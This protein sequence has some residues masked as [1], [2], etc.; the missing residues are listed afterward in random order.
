[1]S[2][3]LDDLLDASRIGRG[4]LLLRKS[5][6]LLSVVIDTALEAARPHIEAKR[7]RLE[8]RLPPTP[9]VLDI[10]PVRIAQVLGNLLTNAAKYT[11]PEGCIMVSAQTEGADFVM[12]VK[13]N[14]IGLTQEQQAHVFDMF[15][16]VPAALEQSQGGLGIGL[17]LAR[18]LVE[19]HGGTI[20]ASSA[21]LGQGTEIIVRLPVSCVIGERVQGPELAAS[22]VAA[23]LDLKRSVLVADD[24]VDAA[25]SLAELLRLE[26]FEV[27]VAYD[28]VAALE[29][30]ARV[31]PDAALLDVSMPQVSGLDVVRVIRG[32]PGGER[33]MLIAVTGWG[34][35]RDRRLAMEAGFDHHLTKPM[36]LDVVCQLIQ[37]GRHAAIH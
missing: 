22:S 10:D 18:G 25:D 5:N 16:Q 21:G 13:D 9:L 15:S 32:Q 26:G 11:H 33:A 1:M 27:Y 8:K 17:A 6:E 29:T 31:D 37:Q 35:E 24:N 30:F 7:H 28:G 23:R 12:R 2:L 36:P 20:R 14:G 34:Q 3:L 4:T 19:L